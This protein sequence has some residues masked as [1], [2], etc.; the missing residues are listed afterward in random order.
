MAGCTGRLSSGGRQTGGSG[1]YGTVYRLA[2]GAPE[3]TAEILY[4]F[5]YLAGGYPD[6]GVVEEG[7]A[8]FGTTWQGGPAQKGTAFRLTESGGVW[9]HEVLADLGGSGGRGPWA[10][11]TVGPDNAL[12]GTTH[13]GGLVYG[14]SGTVFRLASSGASWNHQ[15]LH[16]FDGT[17]GSGPAGRLAV[18]ADQAFYGTTAGPYDGTVFRVGPGGGTWAHQGIYTGGASGDLA[19][20]NDGSLTFYGASRAGTAFRLLWDGSQWAPTTL[21]DSLS[22]PFGGLT[23]A[24]DGSLYGTTA[25]GGVGSGTVFRLVRDGSGTWQPAQ[26][27]HEFDNT[28]GGGANPYAAPVI[29]P[30]GALYG[31]TS[32]GGAGNAGTVYRLAWN[33]TDWDHQVLHS[34]SGYA[35]P[36]GGVI[37]GGP[38]VLYGTTTY[39]GNAVGAFTSGA[40]TVY[41]LTGSGANWDHQ[42]LYAF[43]GTDGAEPRGSLLLSGGS[44]YGTAYAGGPE[45]GGVVFRLVLPV[46]PQAQV[47]PASLAFASLNLGR[48]SAPQVVT[49]A[50]AGG[51]VVQVTGATASGDFAVTNGCAAG[52]AAGATCDLQVRFV[53]TTEGERSGS[54]VVTTDAGGPF[55][56]P[57]GG[58]GTAA[59]ATVSPSSLGFGQV[60][61]A[62]TSAT[63][64]LTLSSLGSG[65]VTLSSIAL[66]GFPDFAL[67]HG[68][69]MAPDTLAPGST[70]FLDVAFT[71]TA[72]GVRIGTVTIVDDAA[73]SPRVVPLGGEGTQPQATVFPQN[74]FFM[75]F[76]VGLTGPMQGVTVTNSGTGT[77]HVTGA[78]ASAN[79]VVT[80]NRCLLGL[81]LGESCTIDVAPRATVPG[82]LVGTLTITTDGFGGTPVVNLSGTGAIAIS[83]LAPTYVDFGTRAVGSTSPAQTVTVTAGGN[84]PLTIDS[85]AVTGAYTFTTTC[86]AAPVA[87]PT[88]CT[89]DVTFVPTA[90]GLAP[91][92]LVITNNS[93]TSPQ[94][95]TLYGNAELQTAQA[96]V[97]P[98]SLTFAETPVGATTAPQTVTLQNTG[99]APLSIAGIVADGDFAR[100]T[101]CPQPPSTLPRRRLVR[102]RRHVH[103]DGPAA[104]HRVSHDRAR[105]ARQPG[106]REPLR[107]GGGAAAGD[108]AA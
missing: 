31:T 56:I 104:A 8:L 88:A 78:D 74:L 4:T 15:V 63:Q 30:D 81:G 64:R 60:R 7:G 44:L 77:L 75:P 58:V 103:A 84:W 49:V 45:G 101:S 66:E 24:G 6:A 68:C 72:L 105:R 33:G 89:I 14:G 102:D 93:L 10:G 47:A 52:A 83:T 90:A 65:P 16:T 98:T 3:W 39:G 2:Q 42:E 43:S 32:N 99:T 55:T 37:F 70:C 92:S 61:I 50:N 48:T 28:D 20:A 13:D 62:T 51:G 57:L 19:V 9:T 59:V 108:G 17:D 21:A 40:G 95:V 73:G 12:Y 76:G 53:P 96:T 80:E 91:G 29:G 97:T 11:L 35:Y 71:P 23:L 5:D 25:Y 87:V 107:D 36:Y 94:T 85:I 22:S 100:T 54:L 106:G 18:G 69:P 27:I 82:S 34:F 86:P 1:G 46:A 38:G 79:F 67:S 26:T 41:R